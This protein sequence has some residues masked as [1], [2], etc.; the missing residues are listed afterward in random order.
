V[1]DSVDRR[2]WTGQWATT[3]SGV[4]YQTVVIT[5]LP[6]AKFASCTNLH[7]MTLMSRRRRL[8][9]GLHPLKA[10]IGVCYTV[11]CDNRRVNYWVQYWADKRIG[12]METTIN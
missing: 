5:M 7:H 11:G 2:V 3:E 8:V 6:M 12:P 1:Y 10:V 4:Q 9:V